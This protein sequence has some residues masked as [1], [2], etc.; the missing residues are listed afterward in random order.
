MTPRYSW[1]LTVTLMLGCLVLGLLWS[2]PS[3]GQ[4]PVGQTSKVGK[5]QIAIDQR[6]LLFCD[7]ETGQ[8]WSSG[9]G[10][11]TLWIELKAPV[12]PKRK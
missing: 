2:Q 11:E 4:A 10:A 9:G 6:G 7:T 5:Y 8:L 12:Y 1:L 3:V